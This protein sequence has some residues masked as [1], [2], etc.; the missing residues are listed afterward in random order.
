[1]EP[2]IEGVLTISSKGSAQLNSLAA[3]PIYG[4]KKTSKNLLL[5]D[6]DILRLILV[7]Q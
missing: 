6:Q 3:M 4:E 5:Q 1:M 2:S 7:Y